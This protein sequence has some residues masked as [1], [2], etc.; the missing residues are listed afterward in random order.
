MSQ[1]MFNKKHI[2]I[3]I[4]TIAIA[5]LT[6]LTTC[7]KAPEVNISQFE[8]VREYVTPGSTTATINGVFDYGGVVDQLK[9]TVG[10]RDDFT[11]AHTF[12][13]ELSEKNFS[14]LLTDLTSSTEYMKF[15]KTGK[16]FKNQLWNWPV[17][18]LCQNRKQTTR[19]TNFLLEKWGC[20]RIRIKENNK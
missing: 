13:A 1:Q 16:S 4:V 19:L 6:F 3:T 5:T 15:Q 11:D 14:V 9:V 18:Y 17:L 10:K 2:F 20:R 12:I 8:I 7:K